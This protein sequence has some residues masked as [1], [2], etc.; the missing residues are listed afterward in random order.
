M[1]GVFMVGHAIFWDGGRIA[2]LTGRLFAPVALGMRGMFAMIDAAASGDDTL[3]QRIRLQD[4]LTEA[5][6]A[7]ARVA[8]LVQENAFLRDAA[9]LRERIP[10]PMIQA[11]AFSY[12]RDGGVRHITVNRG[13]SDGVQV[14]SVVA[15]AHGALVGR[16][17]EVFPAYAMVRAVGDPSLEVTARILSSDI[18]GLVRID[19]ARGLLLDLVQKSEM[20]TEGQT[21]VTSGNDQFPPGLVIGRVRSV[22][23]QSATLFNV[24]TVVPAIQERFDGRVVIIK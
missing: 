1:I 18:S 4:V 15:T 17:I 11:A 2:G 24:V 7:A 8:D 5:Q 20:V 14:G 16:V 23:N 10:G 3:A 21:V 6:A 13:T 12:L 22:D 19:P 9:G